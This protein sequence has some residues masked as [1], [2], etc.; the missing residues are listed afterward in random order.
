MVQIA[1]R[2]IGSTGFGLM[3]FT[4]RA[5]PTPH[6]EAFKTLK[7]A[8]AQGMNFWNG[9]EFYGT[10]E[11][12]SMTLLAAYFKKYPEDADKVVLSMKG[13]SPINGW[14]GSTAG[15]RG[16]MDNIL[17]QLKG[18]KKVDVFECARRDPNVSQA[19]TFAAL[20]EY[21]DRGLLG[22]ISLSE[23]RADTIHEAVKLTKVAFVE[24]EL[25]LF[26]TDVLTNGV[27]A[28]CAQY[29]IPLVAYSPIGRGILSGRF[30]TQ[31]DVPAEIAHWPR[32]SAENFEHNLSLVNFVS[33]LAARKGCTPAQLAISWTRC[34][35]KHRPNSPVIVPIPGSTT[36]TRVEENARFVELTEAEM[37]EIDAILAKFEAKGD[38]YPAEIP[39]DT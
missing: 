24:V 16:S 3:G 9:G 11:N 25:S 6:E 22:A 7:A 30:K 18:R 38:R 27:A 20:Q 29:S 23:V 4:W 14:D 2:E 19:E 12:N 33:D 1:G 36:V 28:A 32:F 37:H 8:L 5:N 35:S 13:A 15:I 21:V 17:S 39:T 31:A 26:S 34:L 10:P